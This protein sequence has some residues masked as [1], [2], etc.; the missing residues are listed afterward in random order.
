MKNLNTVICSIL[1]IRFDDFVSLV[2]TRGMRPVKAAIRLGAEPKAAQLF[3]SLKLVTT[4]EEINE[5]YSNEN[6]TSCMR[7][8]EVGQFYEAN[9][10]GVIYSDNFR[11]LIN[12]KTG[13]LVRSN[14]RS[15][16]GYGYHRDQIC[17]VLAEHYTSDELV[18]NKVY[19]E[20]PVIV[21]YTNTTTEQFEVTSYHYKIDKLFCDGEQIRL[22]YYGSSIKI[23]KEELNCIFK[24]VQEEVVK[25]LNT[26]EVHIP[27]LDKKYVVYLK[28]T[29]QQSTAREVENN[30]YLPGNTLVRNLRKLKSIYNDRFFSKKTPNAIFGLSLGDT[31]ISVYDVIGKVIDVKKPIRKVKLQQRLELV[32]PKDA[33]YPYIDFS[34]D[35]SWRDIDTCEDISYQEDIE[36]HYWKRLG[37]S[38]REAYNRPRTNY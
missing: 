32:V 19:S 2:E 27:C 30:C 23:E 12:V 7:G 10:F 29:Q 3:A 15:T 6:V 13:A 34:Y 33:Y 17:H 16:F 11:C 5:V 9:D 1:N 21:G 24:K 38:Y 36:Q 25:N 22:D 14:H 18:T 20:R 31:I 37:D 8:H 28:K 35:D 4:S 26:E